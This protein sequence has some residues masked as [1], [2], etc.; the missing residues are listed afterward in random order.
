MLGRSRSLSDWESEGASEAANTLPEDRA[1]RGVKVG[2]PGG[3]EGSLDARG[4]AC[5]CYFES[6]DSVGEVAWRVV[7]GL[8]GQGRGSGQ[9]RRHPTWENHPFP[10]FR[11]CS[12]R[13]APHTAL[14]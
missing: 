3:S 11:H 1:Q 2:G 9:P 4:S 7:A 6:S 12:P 13:S 10:Y 8:Q 14:G 5:L